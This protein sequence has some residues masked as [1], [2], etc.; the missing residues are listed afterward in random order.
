[1]RESESLT[2]EAIQGLLIR[3]GAVT[4]LVILTIRHMYIQKTSAIKMLVKSELEPRLRRM[5]SQLSISHFVNP[6]QMD[7][8]CPVSRVNVQVDGFH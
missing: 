7:V 8:K 6:I 3:F 5:K 4:F 1:M 2:Q